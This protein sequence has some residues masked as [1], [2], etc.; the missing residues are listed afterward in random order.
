[1]GVVLYFKDMHYLDPALSLLIA[2]YILW[3][4]FKRLKETLFIFLQGV[5]KEI[6]LV[7]IEYQLKALAHVRSVHNTHIWSLEGEHHVFSTHLKLEPS[8]LEQVME[9]KQ[10]AKE[11][12]K[13]YGF[14]HCTIHIDVEQPNV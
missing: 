11:V 6:D 10:V 4:V 2:A 13:P 12:L 14:L 9:I 5:P 3:G 1:M 8:S 7:K